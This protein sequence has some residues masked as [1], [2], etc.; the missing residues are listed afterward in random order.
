MAR[1]LH[2]LLPVATVTTVEAGRAA[3]AL[4]YGCRGTRAKVRAGH[5]ATV[6]G[7]IG[8]RTV[9]TFVVRRVEPVAIG[10]Q[11]AIVITAS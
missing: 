1:G 3:L 7:A 6:D 5:S 4:Q 11:D 9:G 8:A 10:V 2:P